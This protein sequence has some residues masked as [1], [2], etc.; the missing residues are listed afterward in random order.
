VLAAK[1]KSQKNN[2]Y[3]AFA[4]HEPGSEATV[5]KNDEQSNP[6]EANS[7][8]AI[9]IGDLVDIVL[10]ADQHSGKLTRGEVKELLTKS[11]FHPH[12][13]KVKLTSG[14]IGRVKQIIR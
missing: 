8:D 1:V 10:K 3:P 2:V 11:R 12:G 4:K 14:Q 13:I 6:R 7:R 5:K 9:R